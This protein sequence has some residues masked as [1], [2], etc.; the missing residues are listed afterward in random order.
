MSIKITIKDTPLINKTTNKFQEIIDNF[1][2][3]FPTVDYT[4]LQDNINKLN[5]IETNLNKKLY[6]LQLANYYLNVKK[7]QETVNEKF[8]YNEILKEAEE[9]NEELLTQKENFY[10][11]KLKFV[12]M[13]RDRGYFIY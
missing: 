13:L 2:K 1:K 11:E 12:K 5:D 7:N 8:I 9:L 6:T 10:L 4:T 3:K